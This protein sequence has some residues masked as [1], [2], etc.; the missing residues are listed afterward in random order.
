MSLIRNALLTSCCVSLLVGVTRAEKGADLKPALVKPGK[1]VL[2]EHFDSSQLGKGWTTPKGNWEIKDGVVV[3]KE[4]KDDMHAAVLTLTQPFK[5]TAIRYSF[6]ADGAQGVTLSFN[7][8][9]GHLFRIVINND[10]LV[11]NKDPD[12][13][14]AGSKAKQLAKADGKFPAGQWHTLLVEIQGDKVAVQADNGAKAQVSD[15]SLSVEK[16]GYRFV[17]RG[18]SLLLDDVTI[19]QVE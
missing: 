4:K 1:V 3:G 11:I 14:V 8:P 5:S 7:H 17:M 10:S 18:E 19:W 6:K 12:K 2:E 9:K 15:P 16:T 13:A